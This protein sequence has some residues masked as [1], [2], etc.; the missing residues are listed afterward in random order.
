M[1]FE[2]VDD[3]PKKTLESGQVLIEIEQDIWVDYETYKGVNENATVQQ[4]DMGQ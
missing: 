1:M 3:L 4:D 2:N